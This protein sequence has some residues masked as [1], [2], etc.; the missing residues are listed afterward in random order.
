ML[1]SMVFE[2]TMSLS[3]EELNAKWMDSHPSMVMLGHKV[4]QVISQLLH[5]T[6]STLEIT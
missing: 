2:E 1:R 3:F 4:K 5:F 6:T